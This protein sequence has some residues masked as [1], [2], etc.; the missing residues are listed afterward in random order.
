MRALVGLTNPGISSQWYVIDNIRA[1][2]LLV[3]AR[4][5]LGPMLGC[6]FGPLVL[7]SVRN[8]SLPESSLFGTLRDWV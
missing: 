1:G 5:G 2:M 8:A 3:T 6:L 7:N 4:L